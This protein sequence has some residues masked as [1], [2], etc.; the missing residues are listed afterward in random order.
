[1]RTVFII[2]TL[3][4]LAL[5]VLE[6][7]IA[8]HSPLVPPRSNEAGRP[9]IGGDFVLTTQDGKTLRSEDLRGQY[10]LIYF[11]FTHCPDVCPDDLARMTQTLNLLGPAARQLTPLFITI[12]PARDTQEQL[13]SYLSAFHPAITGLTGAPEEIKRVITDYKI[14]AVKDEDP[15]ASDYVMN[16][17][18]FTYLMSPEG[19][20]LKHFAHGYDPAE[21]AVTIRQEM[22]SPAPA[23]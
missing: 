19:Q 21:A 14:Y 15:T 11:G 10:R 4:I 2:A 18:A 1:M 3:A 13:K 5:V 22:K 6:F 23:Q 12:D 16:H 8:P 20:Y 17:S 9:A 7:F